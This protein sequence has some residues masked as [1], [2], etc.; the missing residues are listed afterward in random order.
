MHAN[1]NEDPLLED[2]PAYTHGTASVTS[3]RNVQ[4]QVEDPYEASYQ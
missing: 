2:N 4:D 3:G 1:V